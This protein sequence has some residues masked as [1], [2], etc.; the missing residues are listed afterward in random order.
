MTRAV[1]VVSLA[2]ALVGCAGS[3]SGERVSVAPEAPSLARNRVAVLGAED[4]LPLAAREIGFVRAVG[5]LSET[6]DEAILARL[7]D[8]AAA[9]GCNVLVRVHFDRGA[10]GRA[11]TGVCGVL[12]APIV[13]APGAVP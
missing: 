11:A 7:A 2:C 8:E 10:F 13:A 6:T 3:I 9:L 5:L 1:V 12:S 4:S